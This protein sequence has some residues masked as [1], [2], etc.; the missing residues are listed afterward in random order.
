M[1]NENIDYRPSVLIFKG[2]GGASDTFAY[3][4]LWLY[5][6]ADSKGYS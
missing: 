1:C 3:I 6:K 2:G 4:R 5:L